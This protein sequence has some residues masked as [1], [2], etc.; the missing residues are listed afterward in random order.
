MLNKDLT[1]Y[2]QSLNVVKGISILI[3]LSIIFDTI[4]YLQGE[5]SKITYLRGVIIYLFLAF[6]IVEY[7]VVRMSSANKIVFLLIFYWATLIPFSSQIFKTI[8]VY[9]KIIVPFVVFII[10]SNL[11][12][13]KK[14]FKYIYV[15][16]S[17][18]VV[19]SVLFAILS[20][21][22][23]FG[24]DSYT[25]NVD[26]YIG[27]GLGDGKLYA[28][29]VAIS[30]FPFI[31]YNFKLSKRQ[32][33]VFFLVLISCLIYSI[34]SVRRTTLIIIFLSITQFYFF[35]KKINKILKI[36]PT[37]V[38]ILFVSSYFWLP[39][40]ESRLK[41]RESRFS[42]TYDIEEEAR[43]KEIPFV[44]DEIFLSSDIKLMLFGKEFLNS[45]GNYANGIFGDRRLHIDYMGILHGSGLVGL[46]FY[47]IV[48]LSIYRWFNKMYKTNKTLT[49]SQLLDYKGLFY[50]LLFTSLFISLSGQMYEV[51]FRTM[52]FFVLGISISNLRN[53][54]NSIVI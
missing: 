30:I 34:I 24:D 6:V 46:F 54:Y 48:Y 43:W 15:S 12:I 14:Y 31:W 53:D 52:I 32:K 33:L 51:T 21:I 11:Y 1:Y 28:Q 5:D 13:N 29:A 4:F 22:F 26:E 8:N 47:F 38:I 20:N 36:I 25:R 45:S 19:I 37:V 41:L 50:A 16:F 42:A 35:S 49:K 44:I 39:I 17:L 40:L 18:V 27:V 3:V 2:K 7:R 23:G 10:S 9:S